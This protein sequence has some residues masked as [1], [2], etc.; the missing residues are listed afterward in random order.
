MP[1]SSNN[2]WNKKADQG[3]WLEGV[4][5]WMLTGWSPSGLR[6][7]M[8]D[9]QDGERL[10]ASSNNNSDGWCQPHILM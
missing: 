5:T 7:V 4:H 6:G 9:L 8:V 1:R 10:L 3:P 2:R